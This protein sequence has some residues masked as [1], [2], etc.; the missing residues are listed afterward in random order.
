MVVRQNTIPLLVVGLWLCCLPGGLDAGDAARVFPERKGPADRRLGPLRELG[1]HYHPWRP[2]RSKKEWES[3]RERIRRRLLVA[4]GLWPMPEKTPLKPV[5]HGRVEREEYTVERVFFASRPG[6]YVTG[7]LYRPKQRKP[8]GHAAVLSPHGHWSNGRFYDAG[9]KTAAK[10]IEQ[11]A[12]SILTAARFPLQARM[13]QLARMGCVVF[14]YDMIGYAD[15]GPLDHRAGFGDVDSELWSQNL[16][17]LQTWNSIRALDFLAS[18]PEVDPQRLAVTGASGGGTQTFVLC[19]IDPRPAVAFPAV[20]VSTAMQGGCVCENASYLRIGLNNIAFAA[21]FAPRPM[22][23]S[24]ADDWT[25]DIETKGLPELKQVYSLYNKSDLVYAKCYPQFKHNYNQVSRGMMYS[26]MNKHLKLGVAEP[27]RERDFQPLT[28]E[29]MTVFT[30][31]HPRPEDALSAA[32]LRQALTRESRAWYAELL[33]GASRDSRE[34]RRIV[35]G[36]AEIFFD[37]GLPSPDQIEAR[38]LSE[39]DCP[40][41]RLIKGW[42]S[43]AGE[44]QQIPYIVLQPRRKT[45]KVTIWIDGGGKS[46]LFDGEGRPLPQVAEQLNEGRTIVSADLYRTGEYLTG[47]VA[48]SLNINRTFPG[49][50]F[51]YNRPLL[52]ERVRDLLTVTA[53]TI[54]DHPESEVTFVGTRGAGVWV[55]LACGL[56]GEVGEKTIADVNGFTF[57]QI[58]DLNN[59]NLLPGALKFGGLGGLSGLSQTASLE[60]YGVDEASLDAWKP[61]KLLGADRV[62]FHRERFLREDAE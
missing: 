53:L 20:M 42:C 15:N 45:R 52:S 8:G 14:H 58:R 23:L 38:Q 56:T 50:T 27:I 35:G 6:V 30:A 61:L 44:G 32:D 4:T 47:D 39:A 11:G 5:I 28:R 31:S 21:C 13:V 26:W 10:Q 29:E 54:R 51:G 43:R 34:Y 40:T 62:Q 16:M 19:A 18:L 46:R 3:Q 7:N 2:A 22:A 24:G 12:E 17:G 37:G 36:A 25:I 49:Y 9:T 60:I 59:P 48:P 1:A 33:A 57:S 41:G 55:L